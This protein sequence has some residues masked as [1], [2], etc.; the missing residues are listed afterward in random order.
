MAAIDAVVA[1]ALPGADRLLWR[2]RFWGGTEQSII[3]YRTIEQPRPRGASV[4]WFLIGLARQQRHLSLYVNAVDDGRYLSQAYAE[5]LGRVR[6][7]SASLSFA[8]S[9]AL[10]L[11][12]LAE[13]VRH[14][15]RIAYGTGP[16]G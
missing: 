13:M 12:V 7:G 3:G 9:D 8:S 11:D 5:R 15:G 4:S 1:G 2:G 6:G 10:D 14:A 16:A